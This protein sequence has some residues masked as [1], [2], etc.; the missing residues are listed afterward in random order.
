VP[1]RLRG[2][3]LRHCEGFTAHPETRRMGTNRDLFGRRKDGT[4]FPVDVGLNPIPTR[5][6]VLVLSV[7]VDISEQKRMERLK[8]EF[9]STVSHELRTP[10]T[11]IAGSLGLLV[12]GVAGKL[13]DQAMRLLMIAQGNSQRLVRLINDILDIEK[14]ESGQ[15][16]FKFKR[17]EARALVEQAME[18]NRGFADTY[19]VRLRLEPAGVPGIVHADPDR[20]SQV[21]TNLLS[22][23][24]KFSPKD[25]DVMLAIEQHGAG[26]RISVRDHGCGVPAE[27]KPRIFE[28]FA[29]A[30]ASDAR[31]KG[32][33]GLGL[34]IV[35][36]IVARLG[37]KVGFDDA[38][39]G[40]TVFYLE[41]PGWDQVA[42]REL[43]PNGLTNARI[44]LCEDDPDTAIGLRES[45]QQFEF[46]TDFAHTADDAVT[47]AVATPYAAI[48]VDH[49]M[50]DR[51]GIDLI[52]R[53][54]EQPGLEQIPIVVMSADAGPAH[55]DQRWSRLD[56][57]DWLV[58]PVDIERLAQILDRAIA[59]DG[60]AR[61]NIL[62]V[63]D[64]HDV[65]DMVAEALGPAANVVSSDSIDDAR[66]AL[67]AN[68]FDLAVLDIA[69][70]PDSGLDLLPDLRRPSGAEIPVIVFSAHGVDLKHGPQVQASFGKS[71]V[72]LDQLVAS[73][74]DRQMLAP[75]HTRK[76]TT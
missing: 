45:L 17:V 74:H 18:A 11:S 67:A 58:K 36:Q 56:V 32:G 15:T 37:G 12:G 52:R 66:R 59:R 6:G 35:K 73:V 61:P 39:G 51:D 70:G 21:V 2:Q 29:Q 54:R 57:L 68:D 7:I 75:A 23:A 63:D 43:D 55:D 62:H 65:L 25:A 71:P 48:L 14:M 20:L 9:V 60:H 22:N 16:V 8:D 27:F 38:A 30:D 50:P 28:K 40:G 3:H 13:P 69:L 53:L 34:S 42:G 33:T 46:R 72:A 64:D 24:I 19:G 5:E 4:E 76:G 10:L 41:L 44:L 31:Q 49:Q 26:V 47:R 1:E